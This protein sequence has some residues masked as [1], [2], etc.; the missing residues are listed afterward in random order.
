VIPGGNIGQV[1]QWRAE[2]GVVDGHGVTGAEGVEITAEKRNA[3]AADLQ[4]RLAGLGWGGSGVGWSTV[5]DIPRED[6]KDA[7]RN[8]I[9]VCR[10]GKGNQ[11]FKP[12]LRS[13]AHWF[14]KRPASS[15]NQGEA[16]DPFHR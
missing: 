10:S 2:I 6:H 14:G 13:R 7:A 9:V 11:E 1:C 12:R 16:G 3:N 5:R 4:A 8:G 15:Q